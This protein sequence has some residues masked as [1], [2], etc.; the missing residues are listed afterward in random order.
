VYVPSVRQTDASERILLARVGQIDRENKARAA[1][2]QRV[3]DMDHRCRLTQLR[4]RSHNIVDTSFYLYLDSSCPGAMSSLRFC[5]FRTLLTLAITLT[6]SFIRAEERSDESA[7]ITIVKGL[8]F[9]EAVPELT[10]D[11]YLPEATNESVPCVITIQGGGF[12]AQDGQRFRSFAVHLATHGFAAAL[13]SYRGSPEHQ[14]RDT[15]ADVQASVRY[16][17]SV[18]KTHRIDPT[19]LGAT[20]RSAGGTLAALLAVTGNQADPDCRIQAAVCFAGVYDFVSRFTDKEQ[21]AMQPKHETKIKTNGEWIGAAF[22]PTDK[23]WLAVSAITHVDPQDPSILFLHSRDDATVP[24]IQS[25]DMHLAMTRAGIPSEIR[26]Y[27]TGGHGVR[28]EGKNSLDA[29]VAFLRKH[30]V[31]CPTRDSSRH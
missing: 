6:A 7:D 17:R 1:V 22:S 8:K 30:L 19:R 14:H 31:Q 4:K 11:L 2:L 18:S 10:L 24:W 12:R 27:E 26:I 13:I 23:D 25:R 16:I 28:P 5:Q 3:G 29:I 21:L 15:V 9:S 20:G